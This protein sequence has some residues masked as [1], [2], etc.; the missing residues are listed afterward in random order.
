[1]ALTLV[2][3]F[4][5]KVKSFNYLKLVKGWISLRD[6]MDIQQIHFSIFNSDF[7]PALNP[8]LIKWT[9]NFHHNRF[10]KSFFV[11]KLINF[12][13]KTFIKR[14]L[15]YN[16]KDRPD[17]I[18]LSEDEYLKSTNKRTT[19]NTSSNLFAPTKYELNS[20]CD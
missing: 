19:S 7:S 15:T 20:T 18:L 8:K 13:L 6:K 11:F 4:K 3:S 14:C 16:A 10:T 1:M 17:V 9:F 2:D 5:P 12:Y